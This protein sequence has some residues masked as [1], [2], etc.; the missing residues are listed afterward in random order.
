MGAQLIFREMRLD[1]TKPFPIV[2]AEVSAAIT[3]VHDALDQ[4]IGALSDEQMKDYQHVVLE[5]LPGAAT[6]PER[7]RS[8]CARITYGVQRRHSF[9]RQSANGGPRK[10]SSAVYASRAAGQQGAFASTR[11]E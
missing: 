3:R 8:V 9:C 5:H 7:D 10:P 4:H 6:V 11:H 2:S 1:Q